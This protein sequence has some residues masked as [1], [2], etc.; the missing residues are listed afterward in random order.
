MDKVETDTCN[1]CGY[2]FRNI[3]RFFIC[4]ECLELL[5]KGL[6]KQT[7][8]SQGMSQRA[9]PRQLVEEERER[10]HKELMEVNIKSKTLT[11]LNN[12][13][14]F[15]CKFKEFNRV[16]KRPSELKESGE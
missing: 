9:K 13:E 2:Y 7:S 3:K 10:I 6:S 14:Y 1:F 11:N 12:E 16:F 5:K 15:V 4:S 8:D